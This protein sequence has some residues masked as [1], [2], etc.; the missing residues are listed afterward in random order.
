MNAW[1]HVCMRVKVRND[2]YPGHNKDLLETLSQ[3][4]SYAKDVKEYFDLK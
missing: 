3:Q 4:F 1:W 2:T